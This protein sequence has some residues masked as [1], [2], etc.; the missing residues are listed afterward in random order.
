MYCKLFSILLN[1]YLGNETFSSL[2]NEL[3]TIIK[4]SVWICFFTL[5]IYENLLLFKMYKIQILNEDQ[6]QKSIACCSQVFE[7]K[8]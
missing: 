8:N 4:A 2:L 3:C 6:S 5:F 1:P 7:S